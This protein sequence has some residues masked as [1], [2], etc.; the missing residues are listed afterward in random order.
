MVP[1]TYVRWKRP[2]NRYAPN[3]YAEADEQA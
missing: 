3:I 1:Q 2:R